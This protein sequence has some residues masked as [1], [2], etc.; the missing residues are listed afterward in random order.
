MGLRLH[1]DSELPGKLQD[2]DFWITSKIFW[3]KKSKIGYDLYCHRFVGKA[4][5]AGPRILLRA[6]ALDS[7]TGRQQGPPRPLY[8]IAEEYLIQAQQWENCPKVATYVNYTEI[9]AQTSSPSFVQFSL[10]VCFWFQT[11]LSFSSVT[12]NFL[13]LSRSGVLEFIGWEGNWEKQRYLSC[14]LL[15]I[16]TFLTSS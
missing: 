3:L 12:L 8:L 10:I 14:I 11:L 7:I 1:T 15:Q 2:T 4:D 13:K 6:L 5:A 9:R 16:F